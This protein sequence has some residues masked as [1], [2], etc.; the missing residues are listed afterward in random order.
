AASADYRQ[1]LPLGY[2]AKGPG[3]F[4]RRS[5]WTTTATYWGIW[6]GPLQESHQNQDVNGFLI[7]KGG[8]LVGNDTMYSQSGI[9]NPTI[10]QN[11][12][13]VGGVGQTWQ[14]PDATWPSDAGKILTLEDNT[15]FSYFAGWG[16][17]AYVQDRSH[18]GSPLLND[19]VR[20]L[21]YVSP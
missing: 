19:Y 1:T 15:Q 21:A 8:W 10:Y 3:L 6:S 13:T 2:L 11:N 14:A 9:M 7:Y 17:Q 20:K 18:G 5:D 16:T 4:T 12:I